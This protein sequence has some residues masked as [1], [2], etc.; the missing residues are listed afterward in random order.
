MFNENN[1]VYCTKQL[2]MIK[3]QNSRKHKQ[4]NKTKSQNKVIVSARLVN[5]IKTVR[6][7]DAQ[8]HC[9]CLPYPTMSPLVSNAHNKYILVLAEEITLKPAKSLGMICFIV[10]GPQNDS[11]I[12][13]LRLPGE[14][15]VDCWRLYLSSFC[16]GAFHGQLGSY[17]RP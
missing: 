16:G 15:F 14:S 7:T 8:G 6:A 9:L 4:G 1:N 10:L 5:V 2:L 11:R 12:F 3:L 17:R 13:V